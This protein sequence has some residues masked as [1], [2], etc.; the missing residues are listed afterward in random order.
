MRIRLIGMGAAVALGLAVAAPA[1]AL[2]AIPEH[3]ARQIREAVPEKPQVAPK[4]PRRVLV[5]VTPPHLMEKDPH[6]RYNIPYAAEAI[7]MLG[8]K[9]GAFEPVVTGDLAHFAPDRLKTC[10]AVV[11]C[12]A[13]Q[14]WI[15]PS[16]EAMQKLGHL[17]DTKEAVAEVLKQNFLDWVR[18]G[19]GVMAFHYAMG[20]NRK[21]KAFHDML[22][23]T[24]WGHPWNEE[25]GIKVEEPDHPL[26]AA[27]DGKETFRLTE[28][29]FQF[30]D[31]YSREKVRVL[32]SLDTSATNM[33]VK[34]IHRK[35]DDFALAWVKPY[36][37]GRVFYTAIG[38]RTEHFWNPMILRFYLSGIQFATGDLDAP[39]EPRG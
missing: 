1:T 34:W 19:R 8:E 5:W 3:R 22:G 14:D 9:T 27:F 20:G 28:E 24:Y 32:L 23:A 4:Q 15:V 21:W 36:G 6:K 12:N 7:K 35:D 26:C 39:A 31:P 33:G 2:E 18:G 16:G 29:I 30:K 11:L 25:V 38:H 17:G 13:S 37:T 10:D